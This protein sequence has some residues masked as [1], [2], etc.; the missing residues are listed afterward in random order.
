MK[1][2]RNNGIVTKI[3][4]SGCLLNNSMR[5]QFSPVPIANAQ[6]GESGLI[7]NNGFNSSTSIEAVSK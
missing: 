1:V 3:G 5:V 4:F 7:F 6:N 2:E